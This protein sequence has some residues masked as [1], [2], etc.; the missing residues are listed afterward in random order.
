MDVL[1]LSYLVYSRADQGTLTCCEL[2]VQKGKV[3]LLQHTVYNE[4]SALAR[5]TFSENLLIGQDTT[6]C[7]ER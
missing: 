1:N 3:N 7:C 2:K 5:L 6:V 4:E